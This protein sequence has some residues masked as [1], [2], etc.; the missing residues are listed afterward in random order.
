MFWGMPSPGSSDPAD[1]VEQTKLAAF[2]IAAGPGSY[3]LCGGWGSS[4][5][6]WFPI[7]DLPLGPPLS[8]ATLANGVYTRRFASGTSVRF[9]ARSEP[10]IGTIDWAKDPDEHQVHVSGH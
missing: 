10:Q 7:Y 3:Y 5:V 2:L 9:D 8:N 4:S 1:P 6:A